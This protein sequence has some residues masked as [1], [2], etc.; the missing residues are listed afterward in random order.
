MGSNKVE[1]GG[2]GRGG[3]GR[4]GEGRGGLTRT[5]SSLIASSFFSSARVGSCQATVSPLPLEEDGGLLAFIR[6][7]KEVK[8]KTKTKT[9]NSKTPI[10][11]ADNY[12]FSQSKPNFFHED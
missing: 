11:M 12:I 2:E 3:E 6:R 4:G 8:K 9:K 7:P 10:T 1:V 5:F